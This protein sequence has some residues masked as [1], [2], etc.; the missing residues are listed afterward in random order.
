M[1]EQAVQ[2]FLA[3]VAEEAQVIPTQLLTAMQLL[4][5]M[6]KVVLFGSPIKFF[7][8]AVAVAAALPR[9]LDPAGRL[10]VVVVAAQALAVVPQP[11]TAAP[12][13]THT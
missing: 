3:P 10:C 9:K 8:A 11:T 12:L 4:L 5:A 13:T 1:A 7:L 2:A 6:A